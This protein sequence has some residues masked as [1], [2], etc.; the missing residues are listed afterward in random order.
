MP[1]WY[2]DALDGVVEGKVKNCVMTF[3]CKSGMSEV[4]LRNGCEQIFSLTFPAKKCIK[5][6]KKLRRRSQRTS[7]TRS[8]SH[9]KMYVIK[10]NGKKEGLSFD[11][12]TLRISKL[13]YN[14]S[15]SVDAVTVSQ[16]VIAGLVSGVTTSEIDQ[17]AARIAAHLVTHHPHYA[18]LAGR[19]AVTDLHRGTTK[20]FSDLAEKLYAYTHEK[21]GRAM[22]LVSEELL[23]VTRKHK[24]AIDSAIIHN[25]DMNFTYFGLMTLMRSYLLRMHGQIVE[26]PQHMYMRVAIGIH[27]DDIER[28]INTYE[29]LSKGVLSHASPTM[30]NSGTQNPQMASCFLLQLP[31]NQD[32]IEDI[33]ACLSNCAKISKTA[34]G[35]GVAVHNVRASGS[36]IAGTNGTSNG[37]TP[38]L[39]VF[40][41]TA[42]YVD[43][44][45]NKR[46]GAFAAYLE[47][48]HADIFEFLDLKKLTGK[49]ELRARDL[50]YALWV[51]DLF[52]ERVDQDGDWT[53][54]CPH[55]CP[56]LSKVYGAEFRALYERYESE[57]RGKKTIKAQKLWFAILASQKETSTPYVLF[58]DHANRKSNQKNLGTIESSNLCVSGDTEILTEHGPQ[59][60]RSLATAH[61]AKDKDKEEDK[62]RAKTNKELEEA[63][64]LPETDATRS[65]RIAALKAKLESLGP[66]LGVASGKAREP[67][68]FKVWNGKQWSEVVAKQTAA[69][70][71]L[72]RITTSW[73]SVIDCTPQ[74][75]FI[76]S[77]GE[78]CDAQD[79]SM[80][81]KLVR[82]PP[83]VY[84]GMP[85]YELKEA[86]A[87]R[88]GYIYC[89]GILKKGSDPACLGPRPPALKVPCLVIDKSI[90]TRET[91]EL[92]GY[93]EESVRLQAPKE[94]H[95]N[96]AYVP[97]REGEQA[98]QTRTM[99]PLDTRKAW[100]RGFLT[101]CGAKLD[102]IRGSH[103]LLKRPWM[104]FRSV[105]E[106]ARLA[107]AGRDGI[108]RMHW[109]AV[110]D[111]PEDCPEVV[112]IQRMG[113][114][115]NT[116]CFTEPLEH[117]GVF[118]E[119][120][121]GQCAEIIEY[122]SPDEISVCNLS[123]IALN[124]FV[125]LHDE[126]P[127][128]TSE[129]EATFNFEELHA[130]VKATV[131]NMNRV[132]DRNLYVLEDMKASNVRHRP[133]GIGVQGLA[134]T[135]ALLRLPWETAFGEAHPDAKLLNQQIFETMYHA[136][137]EASCE[138][139]EVDGPYETYEGS[140]A[141]QGQLQYDLWGVQPTELWDW[142]G[143]KAKIATHGLRNSLLLTCMPTASTAQILGNN[144]SI[145][146]FTTNLYTRKVL[147]GEFQVVNKYLIYDL[148]E[149]G[150]WD[151]EMRRDII[152]RS[153]SIQT[154]QRIPKHI[155]NTY[156]TV[157]EISQKTLIDMSAD[158][159]AFICQSQ[160]FNLHMAD[161]TDEQ[162]TSALFYGWEKG[163]KT[164]MYYLRSKPATDAIK[165][166]IDPKRL[167]QMT[168]EEK[169]EA[170]REACSL[171]NPGACLMCSA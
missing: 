114:V 50:F 105:G 23:E 135:F 150:L 123:S 5:S 76:L 14:L 32:S 77:N 132:I 37:L 166:T 21:T 74:H 160:S 162:L 129:T 97:I 151:E 69:D 142:A 83:V 20:C 112:A 146:P 124:S 25:R 4:G 31:G 41:A 16:K 126:S 6:K 101:A 111:D 82:S 38:M 75:K 118:N 128:T 26:S 58:K 10:R 67:K 86:D 138:L 85:K 55:E 144:E 34:G 108:W 62:E 51:P 53:L 122:S 167:A 89:Y 39:R 156:K 44:G 88:R 109:P 99:A 81:T 155:R 84:K 116:Y 120:L 100:V 106:D 133:I 47:P 141:S 13:C 130:V 1:F 161:P 117:A 29:M 98:L 24:D 147:S 143:L 145:E 65:E 2:R 73:G 94:D 127:T 46:P 164:G 35:I 68:P 54:M 27:G 17:E 70:V 159:G 125:D 139:A 136:A 90:V 158:R 92:L 28:V 80:G 148:I 71:E 40:N 153:G 104:M 121:T 36:Y 95:D 42:K 165:F 170:E 18:V 113:A 115:E 12:I 59:T 52:M 66:D 157:W 33:F 48:W 171:A 3:K 11:K 9:T 87:F 149:E 19:L 134:D 163:L 78:R 140:P 60:I 168:K 119:Q 152:A 49:E 57:G 63:T 15:D 154:I 56:G 64:A 107:P 45:G 72:M 110:R 43:Q 22:P 79:L 7:F 61:E 30:F 8:R 93:N 96:L 102:E 137:L 91:L 169:E 131:V 103:P